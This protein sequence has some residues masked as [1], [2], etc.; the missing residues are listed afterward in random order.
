M[1][2]I[3]AL[4]SLFSTITIA[5]DNIGSD[6]YNN[7]LRGQR[8]CVECHLKSGK[9]M[10]EGNVIVLPINYKSLMQPYNGIPVVG[11]E[12]IIDKN[13]MEKAM[14]IY[15]NNTYHG[16]P[17]RPAYTEKSFEKVIKTGINPSKRELNPI[18]PK[19]SYTDS[20]ISS[21][22][23]YLK[24]ID[25]QPLV[26]VSGNSVNI[27]TIVTDTTKDYDK[28]AFDGKIHEFIAIH[29]RHGKKVI[30]D[31]KTIQYNTWKLTGSPDTWKPQLEEYYKNHPPFLI[32]GGFA[33]EWSVIHEFSDKYKVPTLLPITNKPVMEQ[34]PYTFYWN[35]GLYSE[36]EVAGE[37]VKEHYPNNSVAVIGDLT[38]DYIVGATTVLG[39]ASTD[40]SRDVIIPTTANVN[41][42]KAL[43]RAKKTVV[44]SGTILGEGIH[45]FSNEEKENLK[46]VYPYWIPQPDDTQF[47]YRLPRF[48]ATM[49]GIAVDNRVTYKANTI[50][51][52]LG[53]IFTRLRGD[54]TSNHLVDVIGTIMIGGD[55]NVT[56]D[57]PFEHISFSTKNRF[58]GS[59][60][61]MVQLTDNNHIKL[62]DK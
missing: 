31:F 62:L 50:N 30:E 39:T 48:G 2:K 25:G 13:A 18:M 21:L 45:E 34:S 9:G 32:I 52:L 11:R 53:D 8:A 19:F 57:S 54:F 26:G 38:N 16:A 46:I 49:Y 33:D 56:D 27:V 40:P 59:K 7:G 36:G 20:E 35:G 12:T 41:T 10:P 58:I 1:R 6:I 51:H 55:M 23:A 17:S 4:L 37:Y 24:S 42:I 43:L 5:D 3:I 44:V 29:N 22:L 47:K 61:Q 15:L 60:P 14:Q 28:E